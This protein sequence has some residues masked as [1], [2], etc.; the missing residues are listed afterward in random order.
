MKPTHR[1]DLENMLNPY[2]NTQ[3]T[4]LY[5]SKPNTNLRPN[6]QEHKA[7]SASPTHPVA[8]HIIGSKSIEATFCQNN[9]KLQSADIK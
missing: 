8:A 6:Y 3:N 9:G 2:I 5:L 4:L 7:L 1:I